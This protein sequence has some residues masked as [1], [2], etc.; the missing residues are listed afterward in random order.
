MIS[1]LLNILKVF[2]RLAY[3]LFC[4]IFHV[5]LKRMYILHLSDV[6]F[7]K[8][9]LGDLLLVSF[10]SSILLLTLKKFICS[11]N[12]WELAVK[13]SCDDCEFIYFPIQFCQFLFHVLWSYVIRCIT[14]KIVMFLINSIFYIIKYLSLS[15]IILLIWSLLWHKYSHTSFLMVSAWI[16]F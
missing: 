7:Y 15:W 11:I 10:K 5:C 8:S 16:V 2:N 13:V 6:V 14:F 4:L 12:C 3:C 1:I 9:L